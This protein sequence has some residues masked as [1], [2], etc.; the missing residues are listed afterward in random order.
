VAPL[1][2]AFIT[3]E[4]PS[5]LPIF[6]AKVMPR[7][8]GEIV[9]VAVVSPIYK[10]SSW[11]KQAT[12]FID[13]FGPR[14][15]TVEAAHYA[16]YKSADALRRQVPVGRYHSVKGMAAHHG[17]R[18]LTPDDVNAAGF[19]RRLRDLEP[20]LVISVSCPQIFGRELLELP[21]LGCV[22]VHSALLPD[23]RGMLPTFWA[24]ANGE[25]HTGVTVHYMTAGIDGGDIIRQERIPI[26]AQDTL[27]SLMRKCKSV[28]GDLVLETVARFR[29]GS[30]TVLP[31]VAGEGT[32]FS[33]PQREDVLRFKARGRALR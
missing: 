24:L 16:A 26:S 19:L 2:I 33:F 4:E 13:A 25:P 15:F 28:A 29:D 7:L 11:L 10:R 22:N 3:P 18:I 12:R 8:R 5:V 17:L 9:A 20:D 6:F 1:R 30:V 14:E 27:H 23:Y 31:N 21:R 32:Y